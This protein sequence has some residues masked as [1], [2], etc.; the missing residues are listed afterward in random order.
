MSSAIIVGGGIAGLRA[1]NVL[2]SHGLKVTILEGRDRVGGRILTE[3]EPFMHEMGASWFH[4]TATNNLMPLLK[5][6]NI[7][8][9]F[10]DSSV[11]ALTEHGPA[12]G[13]GGNVKNEFVAWAHNYFKLNPTA[14]DM[15]A[16]KLYQ[17]Y[18]ES[19]SHIDS[20]AKEQGYAVARFF[21]IPFGMPFSE[22][23]GKAVS[24]AG[25]SRPRD[26]YIL[27]GYTKVIDWLKKEIADDIKLGVDVSAIEK[28]SSGYKVTTSKGDYTADAVIVAAPLNVLKRGDISLPSDVSKVSQA[29]QHMSY[30]GM[31][32][33]YLTFD[34][35]FWD[36]SVDQFHY[37]PSENAKEAVLNQPFVIVNL[38]ASGKAQGLCFLTSKETSD[39][40]EKT[41]TKDDIVNLIKPVLSVLGYKDEKPTFVERTTWTQDKYA[42]NGTFS[43]TKVGDDRGA[44]LEAVHAVSGNLQFA[45]EHCAFDNAG[46]ADGAFD[47]G[48][49]AAKKILEGLKVAYKNDNFAKL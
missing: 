27:N 17:K 3:T 14:E 24:G 8:G 35:P 43:S 6:L 31:S 13:S 36:T 29:L 48:S 42:G 19:V 30:G 45:G 40:L 41:S 15:S 22:I 2:K 38:A 7:E 25:G 28:T 10:D 34:K 44:W 11:V 37:I 9:Y 39:L 1:A 47:S 49:V 4:S 16:K 20:E 26:L 5:T 23:S 33:I 12:K 18:A 46:A 32:K 21:E